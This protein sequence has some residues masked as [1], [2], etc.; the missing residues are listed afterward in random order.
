MI[1]IAPLDSVGNVPVIEKVQEAGIKCITFNSSVQSDIPL[2]LVSTDNLQGGQI[3]GKA[4]GEAMGG[5]GKY[6]IVGS[7]E[8][9]DIARDRC[10]GAA[11]YI[12]RTI[13]ACS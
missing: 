9:V 12:K 6:A 11:D 13:R 5:E 2:T 4:L 10:N 3:G 8:A 1:A 7:N